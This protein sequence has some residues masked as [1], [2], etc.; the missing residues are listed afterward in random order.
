MRRSSGGAHRRVEILA[1]ARRDAHVRDGGAERRAAARGLDLRLVRA[2]L[3]R[4]EGAA[5]L[6]VA[7]ARPLQRHVDDGRPLAR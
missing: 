1:V 6:A 4:R 7:L 2:S 5:V 3:C